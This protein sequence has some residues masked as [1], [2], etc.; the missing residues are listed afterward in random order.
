MRKLIVVNNPKDW[1]LNLP[2]VEIVEA[3]IYL[4]DPYYTDLKNVRIFNL[5]RRYR[6]QATG[7]Y[8]SLLAEARGHKAIPSITTI[9]D[10]KTQTIVKIIS[11]DIDYL[12]QKSLKTI[13]SDKFTLSIYFG[14]NVA[15]KYN[16]LSKQ[17]YN[18]FQAPLIRA[19]F[20]F[21]KKW[22]LQSIS[23]IP[24]NELPDDHRDYVKLFAED[25]FCK[26]RYD[27]ARETKFQYD[28]AI[29][30]NPTETECPSDKKAIDKFVEVAENMGFR[31]DLITKDDYSRLGEYDALFIR[32]T[33]SVNHH[34]YRFARRADAEG[35]AVIDDPVSILRCTNK[36]YLAEILSK[37]KIPIPKTMIIHKDNLDKVEELLGLPVVLK[38]PD[39]SFS[40]G[41]IK[42]KSSEQLKHLLDEMLESSDLIIGQEFIPTDYDWRIGIIDRK[43]IYACKYFMAKDHWQIYNWG[44]EGQDQAGGVE[45]MAVEDAP[46]IVIETALK[47]ANLIGN[48]LYG[49]DMK[50][51]ETGVYIIEI[52]D[53]PS[54]DFGSED[55][56][57]KDE[58]YKQ[59]IGSLKRRVEQ[60]KDHKNGTK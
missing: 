38:K 60:N 32:E 14:K 43:A 45:T 16:E 6:Y 41:V 55:K 18:L 46:L 30:I 36:V 42:A 4:T 51:N 17:L 59:V 49:V 56:V 21:N 11:D 58:L 8:V 19:H 23:P 9:Q 24:V 12:I 26:T 52:N 39:S 33:T 50:Q 20:K 37:A 57:I 44:K 35:L 27:K 34:T 54:I 40:Q 1:E 53:N 7:Y 10:M 22:H 48:G 25:Y 5:C 31:T 13:K 29:L 15:S 28:L 2:N 47:A 3:K